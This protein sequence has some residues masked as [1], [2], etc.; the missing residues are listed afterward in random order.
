[1]YIRKGPPDLFEEV[2]GEDTSLDGNV[3]QHSLLVC[4]LQ[5]VLLHRAV[6]HQPAGGK[7]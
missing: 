2:S 1:M 4:L 3:P 6:T 7:C 5:N